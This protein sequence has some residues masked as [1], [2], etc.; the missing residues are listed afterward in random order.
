LR[1]P[2]LLRLLLLRPPPLRPLDF[3]AEDLRAPLFRL[4]DDLRR[5]DLRALPLERFLA[6]PRLRPEDPDRDLFLP[7]LERLDF[8]AAAMGKLRVGGFVE[9]IARFAH[10]KAVG[11]SIRYKHVLQY[12]VPIIRLRASHHVA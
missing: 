2:A 12:C 11:L 1:P 4:A 6:P 7:P 5:D 10:N 3:R 9:R 8:L